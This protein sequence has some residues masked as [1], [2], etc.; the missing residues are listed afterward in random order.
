MNADEF[1]QSLDERVIRFGDINNDNPQV[2]LKAGDLDLIYEQGN[3]RRI[4][5]G[6]DEILRMIYS[7]VRGAGWLT[8]PGKISNEKIEAGQGS[9][10]ISYTWK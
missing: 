4:S 5:M 9:F 3:L 10:R 8:A 7:A 2:K 1:L 6:S